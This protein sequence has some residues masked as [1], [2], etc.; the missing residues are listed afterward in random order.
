MILAHLAALLT[1]SI[2]TL[3]GEVPVV[4]G[5]IGGVPKSKSPHTLLGSKSST[6]AAAA[7]SLRVTENSGV[8]ETTEGVYS[9]SGYGDLDENSHMWFWFFESRKDPAN[10]PFAIWLNGGPGSSSMIGLFQEHGP[11]TIRNDSSTVDL[12]P[13]S[14]NEVANILYIDQPVGVGFSYGDA[15]VSSSKEAAEAVW[16][17]L[18]IFFADSRFSKYANSEF[19]L[20]TESYGGHYGPAFASHFLDQNAAI[21]AGTI[22]GLPINLKLLGIGNGLTDPISQYPGYISYAKSNPYHPLVDADVINSAN[23]SYYSAGGCR[24]LITSC[25]ENLDDSIC[26]EAV[27]DC[28]SKILSPLAGDYNVYYVLS[29]DESYPPDFSKYINSVKTKIGAE[30]NWTQT[31]QDI[32]SNFANT[33]DWMKSSIGDLEKVIDAGIRTVI[34]VGDAV[35]FIFVGDADYICNYMGIEGMV[36]SLKTS[37]SA[38]YA[39]Q[40][41]TQWTVQGTNVGQYKNAGTFS[42]VRIYGAGHEVPAYTVGDL[43]RGIHALT[44]FTQAMA[45]QPISS[46]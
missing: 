37:F 36:S 9:A 46:T 2:T 45:L 4:D 11:C 21:S 42:Y 23:E 8:C 6:A 17:F 5:V 25:N 26:S 16:N 12:N 32:Y 10:A 27:N 24:D 18:Q 41:W 30:I 15:T 34:F 20:W 28:N 35:S 14:W 33:G 39:S 31:S 38:E 29:T 19:A 13:T 1:L 3:A 7:G 40:D 22:S 44:M 43:P